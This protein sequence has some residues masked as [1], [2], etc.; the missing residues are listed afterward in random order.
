MLVFAWWSWKEIS[1]DQIYLHKK[2]LGSPDPNLS[3]WSLFLK[4][5]WAFNK[6]SNRVA[7]KVSRQ[8][9]S[10]SIEDVWCFWHSSILNLGI[11]TQNLKSSTK[12]HVNII[13]WLLATEIFNHPSQIIPRS[14]NEHLSVCNW[15]YLP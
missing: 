8:E 2:E 13:T 14:L 10:T 1:S 7:L 15:Y 5:K 9:G 4:L 12:Q 3:Q 11:D 6:L